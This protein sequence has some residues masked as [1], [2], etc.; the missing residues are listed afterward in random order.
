MLSLLCQ[1][2]SLT[3]LIRYD[4]S[5]QDSVPSIALDIGCSVGRITFELAK[6]FNQVV[7]IDISHRFID[8]AKKLKMYGKLDYYVQT[9]GSLV[10]QHTAEI[11]PDIVSSISFFVDEEIVTSGIF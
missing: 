9:E 1:H 4:L 5:S 8:A 11:D 3:S 6:R 7:G 2:C 10:S